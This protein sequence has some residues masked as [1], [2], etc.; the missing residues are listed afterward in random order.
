MFAYPLD[1][2]S[3][4]HQEMPIA[5][6]GP[7]SLSHSWICFS[8]SMLY[9]VYILYIPWKCLKWARI[10][11]KKESKTPERTLLWGVAGECRTGRGAVGL[12][13]RGQRGDPWQQWQRGNPRGPQS[14]GWVQGS[15]SY[16]QGRQVFSKVCDLRGV[17][18]RLF[19]QCTFK[20]GYWTV[21]LCQWMEAWSR[22]KG[23]QSGCSRRNGFRKE[24][25]PSF[26]R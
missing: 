9:F 24:T 2:E 16:F 17:T 13:E 3:C 18:I 20:K 12:E 22:R 15:G 8:F 5:H 14:P 10:K 21:F 7:R 19:V 1:D 26:R 25:A 23:I 6:P 11:G 4:Q